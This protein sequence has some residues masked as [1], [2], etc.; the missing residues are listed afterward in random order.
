MSHDYGCTHNAGYDMNCPHRLQDVCTPSDPSQS[1][2]E[3][4]HIGPSNPWNESIPLF[5]GDAIVEQPVDLRNLSDRYVDF[6]AE[7][8]LNASACGAPWFLYMPFNH[9]HVPV[10]NHAPRFTNTSRDRGVYGDSM[11]QLDDS[12]GRLMAQL[13][14]LLNNTLVLLT[15]DN[16]APSDQCDY[17]GINHPFDGRWLNDTY[18]AAATGKTTTWEGEA[19]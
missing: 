19:F 13:D 7:F 3:T 15:G 10:G 5:L 16:G 12:I 18:G 14:S 1:D 9:M 6:A 4:C 17:G 11:R 2:P 8:A